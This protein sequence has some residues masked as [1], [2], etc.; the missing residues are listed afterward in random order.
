MNLCRAISALENGYQ[1]RTNIVKDEKRGLVANTYSIVARWRNYFSQP[2]NVRRVK[3]VR[4]TEIYTAE[5][6]VIGSSAFEIESAIEK[7]KSQKLPGIEKIPGQLI[8]VGVE[9]FS[10]R[11]IKLLLLFGI[12]RN[13]MGSGRNRS[14]YISIRSA[15]K[16][17]VVIIGAYH[18]TNYVQNIIPHPAVKVSSICKGN[19][20][21]S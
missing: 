5:P 16:Q 9:Q 14:L 21:G 8:K 7:L 11:S 15:I 17:I 4:H 13:C 12:R 18:F 19:V 20:W 3:G 6:L 10:V 2:L 1:T